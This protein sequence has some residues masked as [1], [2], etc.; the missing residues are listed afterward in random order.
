MD[1]NL[2]SWNKKVPGEPVFLFSLLSISIKA[3]GS[4]VCLPFSMFWFSNFQYAY[5]QINKSMLTAIANRQLSGLNQRVLKQTLTSW[6][7]NFWLK[8]DVEE[9][10]RVSFEILHASSKI[11]VKLPGQFSFSKHIF[12][13]WAA[14]TLKE[15]N[16][17]QNNFQAKIGYLFRELRFLSTYSSCGVLLPRS[18]QAITKL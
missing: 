9:W 6:N 15:R 2:N 1:S 8:N 12:L 13:H 7:D 3:L 14:A 5:L 11:P 17:F 10:S 18:Q 4:K 16:G